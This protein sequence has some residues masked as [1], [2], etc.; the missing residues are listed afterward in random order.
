MS[1]GCLVAT[2]PSGQCS[3]VRLTS[4]T[5]RVLDV[6]IVQPIAL[7]LCHGCVGMISVDNVMYLLACL[8]SLLVGEDVV[9]A[10]SEAT[11]RALDQFSGN[12]PFGSC[13]VCAIYL[14][15]KLRPIIHIL[16]PPR[17]H[18]PSVSGPMVSTDSVCFYNHLPPL[19]HPR[20]PCNNR[21]MREYAKMQPKTPMNSL[22]S[23][24]STCK[25]IAVDDSQ[26]NLFVSG[27]M[28]Q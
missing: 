9:S 7:R 5:N 2:F 15:H 25:A 20:L 4:P 3:S 13:P 21:L 28:D 26:T 27:N 6:A 11:R 23:G 19:Y 18:S 17:R 22:Q 10:E 24:C 8:H 16:M 1:L 12:H 14:L